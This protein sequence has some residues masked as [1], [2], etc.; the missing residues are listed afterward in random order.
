MR[1]KTTKGELNKEF[2]C[3]HSVVKS[4][5]V[6]EI[7]VV[8]SIMQNCEVSCVSYVNVVPRGAINANVWSHSFQCAYI[9]C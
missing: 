6:K 5:I 3:N 2:L 7:M 1:N 9:A 8:M 4:N